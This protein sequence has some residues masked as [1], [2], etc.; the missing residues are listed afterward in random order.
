M[1][2]ILKIF[3]V[4]SYVSVICYCIFVTLVGLRCYMFDKIKEFTTD[5]RELFFVLLEYRKCRFTKVIDRIFLKRGNGSFFF[6]FFRDIF[7]L[8][9]FFREYGGFRQD[10]QVVGLFVFI[11]R[12]VFRLYL[13]QNIGV[14]DGF[15]YVAFFRGDRRADGV[16][17]VSYF[18]REG[19]VGVF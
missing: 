17:Y 15:F 14:E 16:Y 8:Q 10:I 2:L 4:F 18:R 13:V 5:M 11:F 3:R 12:I 7:G 6:E 19:I 9:V 1:V